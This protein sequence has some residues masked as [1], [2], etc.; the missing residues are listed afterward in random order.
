MEVNMKYNAFIEADGSFAFQLGF[1]AKG[2]GDNEMHPFM[3]YIHIEPSDRGEGLLGIATNGQHLHLTDPLPETL[4]E[5]LELT[6]GYWRVL[7]I[8]SKCVQ[9]ARLDDSVTTGWVYPNWRRV[10]P[11]GG[12]VYT[13]TFEG[14]NFTSRKHNFGELAIFLHDFPEVTGINLT[15]LHALGTGFTWNAEWYGAQK[16]LR[17]TE[18]DRTAV[19][20]PLQLN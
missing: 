13:T 15:Y 8:N 18:R 9:I 20:M 2:L 4:V 14:F 19:I 12:P 3:N 6:P 16:A 11:T 17:L 10:I 1:L 5:V 7:K